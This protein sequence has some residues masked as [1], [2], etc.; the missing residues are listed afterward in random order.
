M[1]A[2]RD[3]SHTVCHCTRGY[4]TH[5]HEEF[6]SSDRPENDPRLFGNP[7]HVGGGREINAWV[8]QLAEDKGVTMAP[9]SLAWLL[10]QDVVTAPIVGTTSVE[11]LRETVAA[12]DVVLSDSDLEDLE[13]PYESVEAKQ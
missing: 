9:L 6:T 3:R 12:P 10:Q 2:G 8:G 7:Y 4:L 11:H 13:E 1:R 5:P